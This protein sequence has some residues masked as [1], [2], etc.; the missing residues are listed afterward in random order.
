MGAQINATTEPLRRFCVAA[1]VRSA[2][3]A[4]GLAALAHSELAAALDASPQQSDTSPVY[5]FFNTQFGTHFYTISEAEKNAV[6]A[7]Y[8]VFTF[9]GP[10]YYAATASADGRTPLYRFYDHAWDGHALLTGD[11]VRGGDP[12]GTF[13]QMT[14]SGPDDS[15]NNGAWIKWFGIA[16][17]PTSM[18]FSPTSV[19]LRRPISD[20]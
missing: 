12:Y 13:P 15:G 19:V 14:V 7:N 20:S 10:A 4:F 18:R 16:T 2:F 8:P 1:C 17:A 11:A 9:E 5:R 6:I 3:F